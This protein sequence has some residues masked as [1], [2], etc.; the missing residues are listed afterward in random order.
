MVTGESDQAGA[1]PYAPNGKAHQLIRNAITDE[2]PLTDRRDA[3]FDKRGAVKRRRVH[4]KPICPQ[5]VQ[6]GETS[7]ISKNHTT[8]R[9]R[10]DSP[11]RL[12]G[13][14]SLQTQTSSSR[15]STSSVSFASVR[16]GPPPPLGSSL[17]FVYDGGVIPHRWLISILPTT[18][19]TPH[20]NKRHAVGRPQCVTCEVRSGVGVLAGRVRA[21]SGGFGPL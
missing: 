16:L 9:K 11:L 14:G 17:V 19:V 21:G 20:I 8:K 7:E 3:D 6:N 15:R 5:R 2:E 4:T 10:L 18:A 1:R 12:P 13:S